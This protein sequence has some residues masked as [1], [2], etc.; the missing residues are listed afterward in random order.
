M[1]PDR[2]MIYPFLESPLE[3]RNGLGA[4]PKLHLLAEIISALAA[5]TTLAAR[6]SDFERHTVTYLEPRD[7]WPKSNNDA[8]RFVTK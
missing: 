7:L 2:W 6:N 3:M 1:A 8:G 4:A 5:N